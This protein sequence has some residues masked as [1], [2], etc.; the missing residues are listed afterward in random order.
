LRELTDK[1]VAAMKEGFGVHA[2]LI[3]GTFKPAQNKSNDYLIDRAKQKAKITYS[4]VDG[5]GM[6][7]SSLQESMGP[8]QDRT[9]ENLITSDNIIIQ[10]RQR[11]RKAA[12]ALQQGVAP[13]GLDPETHRVRSAELVLPPDVPFKDSEALKVREA[14]P[15]ATV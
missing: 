6:Q 8:I 2:R 4:G 13:P 14:V 3:P 12:I 10:T 7:D 11:L 9:K 1:E 15:H 5:I